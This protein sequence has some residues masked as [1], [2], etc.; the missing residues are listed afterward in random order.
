MKKIIVCLFLFSWIF[1]VKGQ[2]TSRQQ[3]DSLLKSLP[4]I[5]PTIAGA[6]AALKLADFYIMKKGSLAPDLDSAQ[7]F[8]SKA[9]EWDSHLKSPLTDGYIL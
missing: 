5:R 4:D 1:T 8:I 3:A 6:L 9:Q 2:S 7:F